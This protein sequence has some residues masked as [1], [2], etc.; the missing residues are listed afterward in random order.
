MILSII[1]NDS[2]GLEN[3]AMKKTG[4][5]LRKSGTLNMSKI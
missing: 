5:I 2:K 3:L 4:W 1:E